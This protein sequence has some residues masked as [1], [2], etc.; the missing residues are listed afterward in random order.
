MQMSLTRLN[1]VLS[2]KNASFQTGSMD[3]VSARVDTQWNSILQMGSQ[4]QLNVLKVCQT[5]C[6]LWMKRAVKFAKKVMY[7]TQLIKN[8]ISWI[9]PSVTLIS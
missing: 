2:L 8:A 9:F 3:A 4:T 7:G 1:N 5:V 6:M